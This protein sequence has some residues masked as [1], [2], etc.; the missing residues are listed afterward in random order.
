MKFN[1]QKILRNTFLRPLNKRQILLF[2]GIIVI[3]FISLPLFMNYPYRINIYLSYEG[4]YRLFLGQIPHEDFFLPLGIGYWI[5]PA[6]FFKIIGPGM[7][8]LIIAQVFIN[9]IS[10]ISFR[11]ILK[12]FKV[13]PG[14]ILVSIFLFCLTFVFINFWPWYNHTVFVYE[15]VGLAFLVKFYLNERFYKSLWL[16]IVAAF[17]IALSFFTKQDGGGLAIVFSLVLITYNFLV[18]KKIQPVLVYLISLTLFIGAYFLIF[19]DLS[20]WFNYG[21]YPHSSRLRIFDFANDFFRSSK[22]EKFYL[23][24]ILIILINQ[25]KNIRQFFLDKPYFLFSIFTIGIIIQAILI[26]VTSYIP[27]N[28]NLYF[29]SFSLAFILSNIKL[30]SDLKKPVI[31]ASSL[32]IIMLWWSSDYWK[33]LNRI[34]NKVFPEFRESRDYNV[35]SKYTWSLEENDYRN[36]GEWKLSRYEG[37][38]RILMPEST[39]EGIQKIKDL[40]LFNRISDPKVLNMSELTPLAQTLN[41]TPLTDH[42]LWYH[43]NVSI[44]DREINKICNNI[45]NNYYDLVIYEYIPTLN[46][47]YPFEIRECLQENYRFQFEFEAPRREKSSFI[48]VYLPEK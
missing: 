34:V 29:H 22:W 7:F 4:A 32:L 46:N 37:F 38:N 6:I 24:I 12:D 13:S 35:V 41:Y 3:I 15:I 8:T 17:F 48:E 28:V 33:Y 10:I 30:K 44:F 42:P 1:L 23:I 2:Q 36:A 11:S 9:F 20:Y 21:Q 40:D 19:E 39:I 47:F 5:I 43:K 45:R 18:D 25:V 26:Q 16:L 14:L 31:L 27:H